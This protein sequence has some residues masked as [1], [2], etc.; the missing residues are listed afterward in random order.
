M[1][2]P[3]RPQ[4]ER[5]IEFATDMHIFSISLSISAIF[6]DPFGTKF[7]LIVGRFKVKH[8]IISPSS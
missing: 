1:G 4:L 7:G 6:C 5:D 2:S 3:F 8:L